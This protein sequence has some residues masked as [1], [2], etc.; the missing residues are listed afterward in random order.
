MPVK[1]ET[2]PRKLQ[3][4][5]IAVLGG[6]YALQWVLTLNTAV[7]QLQYNTNLSSYASFFIGQVVVPIIFFSIAFF[8][9]P[10]KISRV[11]RV[12][13]S[14]LIMLIGQMLMQWAVQAATLVQQSFAST[15]SDPYADFILYD[16]A[17]VA[18]TTVLYVMT[19]LYLRATKRWK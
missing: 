7:Q 14:L 18:I 16:L 15:T 6:T 10:R 3:L 11:G 17:A 1:T 8:L 12:F 4:L 5:T 19:L 13:E 9:N 2:T